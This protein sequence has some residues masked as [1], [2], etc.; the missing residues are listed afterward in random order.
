MPSS[1]YVAR[2]TGSN[3]GR[4]PIMT[5][6]AV[7]VMAVALTAVAAVL[8]MR[9]EVNKASVQWRG[10]VELAIFMDPQATSSQIA[11][12]GHELQATPGVRS[13]RYVN[14]EGAYREFRTM[15][16]SNPGLVSVVT[17]TVLPSSYRVVPVNPAS[18]EA[19]GNQFKNSPGVSSVE[20]AQKEINALISSFNDKRNVIYVV[21]LLVMIGATALI[22]NTIQLAIF[23]RRR[24]VAVMKLV[25]ATNWFIRLPFMIEGLIQGLLGGLVA[26]AAGFFIR[27]H[28]SSFA[29]LQLVSSQRQ[30]YATSSEA[31][32]T[33][34]VVLVIGAGVGALGS[35][36][37]VRR[38]LAV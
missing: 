24:E 20:Y 13:V 1:G 12:V 29:N 30:L 11:S 7:V 34:V 31:I 25:G 5:L 10:G 14:Q 19:L 18:I 17:P 33:G 28:L 23:A 4:N 26:A 22:V 38:F 21:A 3:L 15:F 16:A 6:A 27:N 32:I 37:A 9:Q 35:A 8:L 36:F 2:E